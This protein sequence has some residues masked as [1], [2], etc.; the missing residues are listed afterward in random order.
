MY[1]NQCENMVVQRE[2]HAV[3]C[4][5]SRSHPEPRE[6]VC[7]GTAPGHFPG[8][9]E[10]SPQPRRPNIGFTAAESFHTPLTVTEREGRAEV[11]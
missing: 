10:T 5:Q 3:Q 1:R 9:A 4:L 6:G 11:Q 7:G 8:S 2:G